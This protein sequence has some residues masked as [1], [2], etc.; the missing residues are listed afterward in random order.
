MLPTPGPSPGGTGGPLL[1]DTVQVPLPGGLSTA[2][3][4]SCHPVLFPPEH[5]QPT[6][7][8]FTSVVTHLVPVPALARQLQEDTELVAFTAV[9]AIPRSVPGTY[10]VRTEYWLDKQRAPCHFV[11]CFTLFSTTVGPF[12]G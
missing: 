12:D 2:A 8:L 11:S 7:I 9:S 4:L 10:Q 6:I 1:Q 3:A 5:S